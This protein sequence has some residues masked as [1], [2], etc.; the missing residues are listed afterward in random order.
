MLAAMAVASPFVAPACEPD[1]RFV[2]QNVPWSAYSRMREALDEANPG[3]RLT[4]L[5]GVLELMSPSRDHEA[6]A[7]LIA[8][9]VEAFAEERGVS[10]NGYKS[11]TFRKEAGARGLEPDECYSLGPLGDVPDIAIEVVLSSG[12]IDKLEVYRGLAVREVWVYRTGSL[13]V[14]RLADDAYQTQERS[15][16]LPD[17]DLR[18]LASFVAADADQTAAVRAYRAR[19]SGRRPMEPP[20]GS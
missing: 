16:V 12:L 13:E 8:R 15:E 3:V 20:R 10:L 11:A 19:L 9:L 1:R 7:K 4:Y 5:E 18:E 17:L 6:V 2:V 14:Y